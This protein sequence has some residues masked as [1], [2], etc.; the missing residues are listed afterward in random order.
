[1][2]NMN[3]M[4]SSP[5]ENDWFQ[6]IAEAPTLDDAF[7]LA[8]EEAFLHLSE[9][10][11]PAICNT[12]K[13]KLSHFHFDIGM[14]IRNRYFFGGPKL[15][16]KFGL[17][18]VMTD[19][20]YRHV[21]DHIW[22]RLRDENN[23]RPYEGE[24]FDP[25][26]LTEDDRNDLLRRAKSGDPQAMLEQSMCLFYDSSMSFRIDPDTL[27]LVETDFYHKQ[28][29]N[30]YQEAL[31][32]LQQAEACGGYPRAEYFVGL[33]QKEI[34]SH[35]DQFP[36]EQEKLGLNAAF[37]RK[38]ALEWLQRAAADG[39]A[40][41]NGDIALLQETCEASQIPGW[42]TTIHARE[43]FRSL[44]SANPAFVSVVHHYLIAAEAGDRFSRNRLQYM[45]NNGE[46]NTEEMEAFVQMTKND[47]SSGLLPLPGQAERD[48][49]DIQFQSCINK[50]HAHKVF[51]MKPHRKGVLLFEP[52][53]SCDPKYAP[54]EILA[55]YPSRH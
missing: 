40:M 43:I 39:I 16:Q 38:T 41:A 35:L 47:S 51:Q 7:R 34:W 31:R 37:C 46:L 2:A 29:D 6:R 42:R 19:V 1:M 55:L 22:Q 14:W 10:N 50:Q 49:L 44:N 54:P 53:C 24:A 4:N 18:H 45:H 21:L 23:G 36:S 17:D 25:E 48:F 5:N 8:A 52:F 9:S 32:W 15:S 13:R 33:L 20:K 12:P 26:S 11:R 27:Q 30:L 3:D 28:R